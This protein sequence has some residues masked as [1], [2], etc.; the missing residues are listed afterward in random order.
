MSVSRYWLALFP[1][2]MSTIFFVVISHFIAQCG[3]REFLACECLKC[4]C[5][6]NAFFCF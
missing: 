3:L 5:E 6:D 1:K 4:I 2:G